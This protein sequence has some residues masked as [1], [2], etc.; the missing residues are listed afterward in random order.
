MLAFSK[1]WRKSESYCVAHFKACGWKVDIG[2]SNPNDLKI[3]KGILKFYIEIVHESALQFRSLDRIMTLMEEHARSAAGSIGLVHVSNFDLPIPEKHLEARGIILIPITK[4]SLISDLEF[5][6]DFDSDRSTNQQILMLGRNTWMCARLAEKYV[7]VGNRESALS[8][9]KKSTALPHSV[10]PVHHFAFGLL[11]RMEEV[12]EAK[13][14]A[15]SS[16]ERKKNDVFFL[17]AM[18]DFAKKSGDDDQI[19]HWTTKLDAAMEIGSQNINDILRGSSV[20]DNKTDAHN[21]SNVKRNSGFLR[22]WFV[23][24]RNS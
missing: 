18:L 8:W 13:K 4:L 15:L 5:A 3:E 6:L 17:R 12:D 7:K 9:I 23:A 20:V 24:Q 2:D 19:R 22:K 11:M 16:L 1:D 10:S 14:L 21:P